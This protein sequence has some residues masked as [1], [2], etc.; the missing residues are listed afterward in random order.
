[1]GRTHTLACGWPKVDWE[2]KSK[3]MLATARM[4]GGGNREEKFSAV[5]QHLVISCTQ[6]SVE[7]KVTAALTREIAVDPRKRAGDSFAN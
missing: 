3:S 4:D 2:V 7:I 6:N 1:V 5:V